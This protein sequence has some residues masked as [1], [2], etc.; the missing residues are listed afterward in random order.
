M[1]IKHHTSTTKTDHPPG[2][3]QHNDTACID[4]IHRTVVQYCGI[5]FETM[6][7]SCRLVLLLESLLLL[8]SLVSRTGERNYQLEEFY[9]SSIHVNYLSQS[10]SVPTFCYYVF[11]RSHA[12]TP[13][14]VC[15]RKRKQVVKKMAA[16]QTQLLDLRSWTSTLMIPN[17]WQPWRCLLGC[18]PRRQKRL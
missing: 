13:N 17:C 18:H 6:K 3:H 7:L 4:S 11:W 2:H 9:C 12:L 16:T 5:S 15:E 10:I 8:L 14:L 1:Y